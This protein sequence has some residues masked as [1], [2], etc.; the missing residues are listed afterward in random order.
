MT[1]HHNVTSAQFSGLHPQSF[2]RCWVLNPKQ[3]VGQQFSKSKMDFADPVDGLRSSR[4]PPIID[5]LLNGNVGYC[6]ELQVSFS[7]IFAV[8]ASQCTLDIYRMSV[9]PL[10]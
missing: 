1:A 10:D 9:M 8:I 5:P 4:Q 2:L 7:R 6:F 3:V